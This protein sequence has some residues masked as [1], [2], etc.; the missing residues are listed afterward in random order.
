MLVSLWPLRAP[1]R[2]RNIAVPLTRARSAFFRPCLPHRR[3]AQVRTLDA[4]GF[5][6]RA[7]T[8]CVR[9]ID[10]SV[11]GGGGGSAKE[12][13]EDEDGDESTWEVL[14]ISSSN[15]KHHGRLTLPGGGVEVGETHE[16]AALRETEEEAGVRGRLG[17][18]L[19]VFTDPDRR[20]RTSAWI[21]HVTDEL[22]TWE[23]GEK[24][25]TRSWLSVADAKAALAWKPK[26]LRVCEA[27]VL[28]LQRGAGAPGP[29]ARRCGDGE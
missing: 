22:D 25:R 26:H 3:V 1:Q 13:E 20:S 16:F 23:E 5:K 29:S 21:L 10:D 6:Q 4:E 19:G 15:A 11:A 2:A 17:A 28:S 12:G 24:G 27:A 7:G 9:R 14:L 18:Y 8:V